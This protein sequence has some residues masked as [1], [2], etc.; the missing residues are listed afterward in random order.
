LNRSQQSR[1]SFA[2][3]FPDDARIDALLHAFA[4]GDYA[5]V[6]RDGRSLAREADDEA[7]RKAA[8][9]IVD[10]TRPDPLTRTLLV[11]AALLLA[12]L[13]AWWIVH[14]KRP[15]GSAAPHVEH[16]HAP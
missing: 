10:R 1:P 7:V 12:A 16:V 9:V 2:R 5:A 6:Q 4:R 8:Q 14:G 13:S 11:L 15:P 3:L